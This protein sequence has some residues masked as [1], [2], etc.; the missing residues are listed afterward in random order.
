VT[1]NS[2]Q[3]YRQKAEKT[4]YIDYLIKPITYRELNEILCE[5]V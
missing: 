4:N 2:D 1:G 3:Y 5:N